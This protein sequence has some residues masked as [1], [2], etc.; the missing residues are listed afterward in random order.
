MCQHITSNT[1]PGL[2]WLGG[3]R[4]KGREGRD[5]YQVVCYRPG[6]SFTKQQSHLLSHTGSL[7]KGHVE[8]WHLEW[9][10]RG[11]ER[12]IYL[13]V[14]SC[15]LS[16]WSDFFQWGVKTTLHF[17]VVL[18]SSSRPPLG[19]PVRCCGLLLPWNQTEGSHSLCMGVRSL[20]GTGPVVAPT[21]ADVTETLPKS[22]AHSGALRQ[23]AALGDE[24]TGTSW[25]SLLIRQPRARGAGEAEQILGGGGRYK[26]GLEQT[27]SQVNTHS[28]GSYF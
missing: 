26:L 3:K 18:S 19:K 16:P 9:S 23:M 24:V 7:Q 21:V 27:Y 10:I 15:L 1:I 8:S 6:Y 11:S 4:K 14:L 20:L 5:K 17:Q 22:G 28:L 13:L 12:V 25:G 2:S